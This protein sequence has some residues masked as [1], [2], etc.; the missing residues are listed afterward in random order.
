MLKI[1]FGKPCR[2]KIADVICDMKVQDCVI[3]GAILVDADRK[4]FR[5]YGLGN[6]EDK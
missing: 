5:L 2:N 3:L 1:P 6:M 4:W